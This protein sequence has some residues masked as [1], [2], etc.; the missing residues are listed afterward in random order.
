METKKKKLG[1]PK[2][3]LDSC[4]IVENYYTTE[5]K[6]YDASSLIQATREQKCEVFEIP[7]A[8]IDLKMAPWSIEDI[9]SFLYH[10]NRAM[11]ADEKY[12][13]ILDWNGVICDGWHRICKALLDGKRTIKAL[14]LKESIRPSS[15]KEN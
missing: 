10:A 12:P 1:P 11:K 2:V 9:D 6:T 13:I 3:E 7:L 14:R 8:A 15:V 5:N 4:S